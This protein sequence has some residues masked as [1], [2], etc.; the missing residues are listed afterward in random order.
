MKIWGLPVS[1]GVVWTHRQYRYGRTE[2]TEVKCDGG[3]FSGMKS[4]REVQLRFVQLD[5]RFC[6]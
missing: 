4:A 2:Q 1:G 5:N 6:R 3:M